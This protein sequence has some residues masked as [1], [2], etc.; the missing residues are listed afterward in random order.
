[1]S[2]VESAGKN[3]TPLADFPSFFAARTRKARAWFP[4]PGGQAYQS[5]TTPRLGDGPLTHGFGGGSGE[6]RGGVCFVEREKQF[7]ALTFT[8]ERFRAAALAHGAIQILV[9]FPEHKRRGQ[10]IMEIGARVGFGECLRWLILGL[11]RTH[12]RCHR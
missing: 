5:P 11:P 8:R 2:L 10:R 3:S 6:E 9:R 12:L 7:Y 1:L 4:A